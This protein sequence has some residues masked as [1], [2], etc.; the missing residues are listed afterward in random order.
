M[1]CTRAW[2]RFSWQCRCAS[3]LP[4]CL[5]FAQSTDQPNE[6]PN[7]HLASRRLP[8]SGH[9]L[10]AG[11]SHGYFES[12]YYQPRHC[13][14]A[15]PGSV[16]RN[17]LQGTRRATTRPSDPRTGL[18]SLHPEIVLDCSP[19]FFDIG[20]CPHPVEHDVG[21]STCECPGAPRPIPLVE[22]VTT[23]VLPFR[24]V[25]SLS[26]FV[27]CSMLSCSPDQTHPAGFVEASAWLFYVVMD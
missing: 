26:F 1:R 11:Q 23:A 14:R 25:N 9:P 18:D 17:H 4:S 5:S 12:P 24:I 8:R 3:L 21:A 16:D 19:C 13:W 22:P 27:C 6:Q 2:R 20:R 7:E 15:A 10:S